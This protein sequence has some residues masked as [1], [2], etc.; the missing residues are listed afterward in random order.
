[1]EAATLA[2]GSSVTPASNLAAFVVER[3]YAELGAD[4]WNTRRVRVLM[5]KF[6]DTPTV[7]AARVR[8]KPADFARRMETDAWTKQDGLILSLLEREIDFLK[9]GAVPA[10]RLIATS[11]E[12][13]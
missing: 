9:G 3:N 6:G 4:R 11:G 13:V 8:L 12:R 7:M 1:M 2:G 5:V 10:G